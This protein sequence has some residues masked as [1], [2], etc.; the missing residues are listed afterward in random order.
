MT[1][2]RANTPDE[3]GMQAAERVAGWYLGHRSWAGLL[4]GAYLNPD[5]AL[6]K[7]RYEMGEDADRILGEDSAHA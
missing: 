3:K 1:P 4:I 2:Q 7:L 6:R 5:E